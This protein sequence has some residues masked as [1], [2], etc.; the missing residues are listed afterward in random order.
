MAPA[1]DSDR[2][3]RWAG[4]SQSQREVGGTSQYDVGMSEQAGERRQSGGDKGK[5]NPWTAVSQSYKYT[6]VL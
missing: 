2:H 1:D 5:A 4:A 6:S 3:A